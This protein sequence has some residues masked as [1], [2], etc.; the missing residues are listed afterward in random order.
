M[1]EVE[2]SMVQVQ[3]QPLTVKA[4]LGGSKMAELQ[5][6]A[7]KALSAERLIKMFAISA[8]RTPALLNCTPLSVLDAMVKCAELRLYPGTLGSVYLIP[9][10]NRKTNTTECQFILGY[11]G[12]MTLA[13]RSGQISTITADVVRL[14]DEFDYEH[15]LQPKFRHRP[16]APAGASV[17]HAWALAM[18]KDGSH[19]LVVMRKDELDAVRRRSRAGEYGPWKTDT[20][21]MYKK[22]VLRRLCKYL[23]LEPEDEASLAEADRSEFEFDL[24]STG[25]DRIEDDAPAT[26]ENQATKL[27]DKLKNRVVA[28]APTV[29]AEQTGTGEGVVPDDVPPHSPS[30]QAEI[31]SIFGPAPKPGRRSSA[32]D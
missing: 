5:K 9:F 22:T 4:L 27:A 20:D 32:R 10:A 1:S 26:V 29:V 31:D 12:M 23:P 3:Q 17:T 24:P 11:K 7:G 13:R 15:G 18:F 30:D 19:Q 14:G 25:G 21:E 8:S 28:D 2:T 6:V 16:I